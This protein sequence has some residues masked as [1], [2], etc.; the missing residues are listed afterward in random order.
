MQRYNDSMTLRVTIGVLPDARN[1]AGVRADASQRAPARKRT[2]QAFPS[3]DQVVHADP[4]RQDTMISTPMRFRRC[5]LIGIPVSVAFAACDRAERPTLQ[6]GVRD[7]AG[8]TIVESA[9]PAWNP[10]TAW[11]LDTAMTLLIGADAV[12]DRKP[13]DPVSVFRTSGGEV[14]V[15]DGNQVGWNSILVYDSGGRWLRTLGRKG[16]GP[17]EFQQVWWAAPYRGDS[18]AVFDMG[19]Q[20]VHILALDGGCGGAVRVP[21]QL[22]GAEQRRGGFVSSAYAVYP[23][24]TILM[25][26]MGGLVDTETEGATWFTHQ[27]V[28]V[29]RSGG[30]RHVLGEFEIGSAY[31]D[32]RMSQQL[33]YGPFADRVLDGT[34]LVFGTGRSY[35]LQRFDSA[36]DLTRIM[37]RSAEPQPV[38]RVDQE[39]AVSRVYVGGGGERGTR[40]SRPPTV[41]RMIDDSHWADVKPFYRSILIDAGGNTWVE[42]YRLA[43]LGFAV[44]GEEPA[45]WSVFGPSGVWLGT[46]RVPTR[47]FLRA[48][49]D[50][51]V[52]GIWQDDDGVRTV[53]A[54]PLIKPG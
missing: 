18:V 45:D 14:V 23:D 5:L 27:L 51:V 2:M 10:S 11:R 4:L 32:G 39:R 28:R 48:V 30:V 42:D 16:E 3:S 25:A 34:D 13:L 50:D 19:R 22:D 36:G 38:R 15:A 29:E 20:L 21:R 53:R 7:S 49:Y 46:V 41:D 24:G 26:P 52:F 47:F 9:S 54:Y 35:E 40:R 6:N 44:E 31:W 33:F 1:R 43:S 8:I 12:P 17:C 37:R